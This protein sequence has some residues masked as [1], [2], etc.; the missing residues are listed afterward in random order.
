MTSN[1]ARLNYKKDFR[2]DFAFCQTRAKVHQ[3]SATVD[4]SCAAKMENCTGGSNCTGMHGLKREDFEAFGFLI[5]ILGSL[6]FL[7]SVPTIFAL[8]T[9]W[10]VAQG[11]KL[12]LISTLVAG[13]LL[14]VSTII[15]G[16][17]SLVMV[18]T[19][20]PAPPAAF[21]RIFIWLNN[22]SSTARCFNVVGFSIVVLVVVRFGKKNIKF[23][24]IALSLCIVW[25]V[26]LIL[27]TQYLVPPVY[28]VSFI[29]DAICLPVQDDT[30]IIEARYFFTV[31]MLTIITFFPLIVCITVSIIVFRYLKRHNITGDINCSKAVARLAL[32]LVTGNL[33]NSTSSTVT[34]IIAYFTA[35]SGAVPLIHCVF[36]IGLLSLYP[37]PIL[38]LAFLKPVRDKMKTFV[39]C[40]YLRSHPS[41]AAKS[42]KTMS[43]TN[44][45]V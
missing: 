34:S 15:L 4:S 2:H 19:E 24:Y 23:L 14:S 10:S 3:H 6:L 27:N 42:E 29:A 26:S 20:A 37:T 25:G 45:S 35:G 16:L 39:K 43:T 18:F 22:I 21:C 1:R 40:K 7:V 28:A 13:L 32:F 12:Y 44:S 38:I 17:I 30:I 33:I 9:T 31:F 41:V 11:L 5:T 8:G 36:I